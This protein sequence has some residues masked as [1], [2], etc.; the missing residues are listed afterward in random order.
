VTLEKGSLIVSR[1]I[2]RIVL[3]RIRLDLYGGERGR[4]ERER[5]REGGKGGERERERERRMLIKYE[6]SFKNVTRKTV[7]IELL[8]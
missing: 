4:E 8:K 6:T 3:T 7:F 1:E 5:R 2:T